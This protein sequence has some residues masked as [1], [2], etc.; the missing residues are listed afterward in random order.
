MQNWQIKITRCGESWF[1]LAFIAMT[2]IKQNSSAICMD[3]LC[4]SASEKRDNYGYRF[5]RKCSYHQWSPLLS[6]QQ[7]GKYL[8]PNHWKRDQVGPG[9]GKCFSRKSGKQQQN[10]GGG[11]DGNGYQASLSRNVAIRQARQRS[12]NVLLIF[13][14]I[15]RRDILIKAT[16]YRCNKWKNKQPSLARQVS[17]S[18]QSWTLRYR[19]SVWLD[20][21]PTECLSWIGNVFILA[22]LGSA[23]VMRILCFST[24]VCFCYFLL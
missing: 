8:F 19:T 3:I 21:P 14:F 6:H 9:A 12:L 10:G 23:Q 20:L 1:C 22:S 18:P 17:N 4:I 11:V 2:W 7:L 5:S 15:C 16:Y 24:M 13:W